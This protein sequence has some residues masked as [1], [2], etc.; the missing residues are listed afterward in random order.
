MTNDLTKVWTIYKI[1]NTINN[2]KYIGQTIN[3]DKRWYQHRADAA[4]AKYPLHQAINKYGAEA[5]VFEEIAS[6]N[7]QDDANI[8]EALL[9]IQY[10]SLAQSGNGYN[11]AIGGMVAPK[12]EEH[13]QKISQALMGHEVSQETR[14]KISKS[15][16]GKIRSDEFKKSVSASLTGRERSEEHRYNL[17]TALKGNQNCLGNH[18]SEETKQ[19]ISK[20]AKGR[21]P[22]PNT[23]A[24]AKEKTKGKTWKVIDGKR[25]WVDKDPV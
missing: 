3:P 6:C 11:I 24:K 15:G 8:L 20:A 22:S 25:T 12:T 21:S 4:R 17:S 23:I 9:I 16:A 13:K 19:K 2:K 18:H 1:T 5:F 7:N 10:D 14:D